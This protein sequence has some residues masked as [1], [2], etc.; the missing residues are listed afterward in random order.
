MAPLT[1]RNDI[2]VDTPADIPLRFQSYDIRVEDTRGS[3]RGLGPATPP[4][5]VAQGSDAMRAIDSGAND[6]RRLGVAAVGALLCCTLAYATTS[7]GA[8]THE[9][10]EGP[11]TIAGCKKK[12]P[13]HDTDQA[14]C[15]LRVHTAKLHCVNKLVPCIGPIQSNY[16]MDG[17]GAGDTK[18]IWAK[19]DGRASR[20][21]VPTG[22]LEKQPFVWH[23]V[24]SV[25]I[26]AVFIIHSGVRTVGTFQRV[27]TG[28]HSGRVTLVWLHPASSD[29]TGPNA[30][31]PRLLLEGTR[32]R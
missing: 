31:P 20:K 2:A 30:N 5:P 10:G 9:A 7:A 24:P 27:P 6:V 14:A 26:V 29:L 32:V 18:L 17:L 4:V 1:S 8:K 22:S 28:S 25:K 3:D 16:A 15:L 19:Y 23:S 12:Y 13:K 11:T 21:L